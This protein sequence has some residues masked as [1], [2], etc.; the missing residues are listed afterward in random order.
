VF[1]V[2]VIAELIIGLMYPSSMLEKI[3]ILVVLMIICYLV[4]VKTKR[5]IENSEKCK[6]PDYVRESIGFILSFQNI[7]LRILQLRRG[8]IR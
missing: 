4:L 5:M 2:L 6:T 7:I 1:L 3:I 8:R